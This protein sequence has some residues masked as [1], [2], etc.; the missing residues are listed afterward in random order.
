MMKDKVEGKNVK[1]KDG[2]RKEGTSSLSFERGRLSD[3]HSI[4]FFQ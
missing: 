4:Y 1:K 2:H 3:F